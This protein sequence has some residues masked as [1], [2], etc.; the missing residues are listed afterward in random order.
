[1]NG[2]IRWF[3]G[4]SVAANFLMLTV[5]AAGLLSAW[6]IKREL[7]PP[8]TPNV[9]RVS[10]AYP[11]ATPVE[12]EEGIILALEEALS[13]LPGFDKMT[14][15]AAEGNGSVTLEISDGF[16]VRN[17]LNDTKGRVDSIRNF[18]VDAEKPIVDS[19]VVTRSILGLAVYGNL[20]ERGLRLVA[21]QVRDDLL[22]L[23]GLTQV[24][25]AAA[26]AYEIAIEVSEETLRRYGMTLDE[27]AGAV[28]KSSLDLPAGSIKRQGGEILLRS[29]GQA[30]RGE[31]FRQLILR[32]DKNGG[33][34]R[35]QDVAKVRDGFADVDLYSKF[36]GQRAILVMVSQVGNQDIM[37]I[38]RQVRD[39]V[40]EAPQRLQ[41]GIG[42]SI[43]QDS[44][45]LYQDRMNTLTS[46]A[47]NGLILVFIALALFLRL[48]LAIWV[49][50]GIPMSFLGA[51][52]IM[53]MM[54][55]SLN[56][57]SMFAFILVLGIVVDDAIVVSEAIHTDQENGKP[58]KDGA[59]SGVLRVARPVMM[60]VITTLIAFAP[61]LFMSGVEGSFWR[62][63][64]IV[65]IASL[66]FSLVE[67]LLILPAHLC[68][69]HYTGVRSRW[70]PLYWTAAT[71]DVVSVGL[72]GFIHR[73]YLPLLKRALAWRY[74]TISIFF[75]LILAVAGYYAGGHLRFTGFPSFAGD[76]IAVKIEMPI[77]SHVSATEQVLERVVTAL[78]SIRPLYDKDTHT[79]PKIKPVFGHVLLSVGATPGESGR[80]GRGGSD[81]GSGQLAEVMLQC[82][83]LRERGVDIREIQKKWEQLVGQPPGIK[84][85][86]FSNDLGNRGQD[87]ALRLIGPDAKEL[88]QASTW[89]QNELRAIDGVY[90]TQ[91]NFSDGKEEI[92]LHIT[93]AAQTLGLRQQDL[94]RQVRQA[95]YGEEVQRILRGRDEI[96]VMVRYPEEDRRRLDTLEQMR[97]RTSQGAEVPFNDV[98]TVERQLG[99][100]SIRR[101]NR[102]R[103]IKITGD[104]DRTR[105]DPAKINAAFT[106]R[107]LPELMTRYPGV[108]G[109]FT[110]SVERQNQSILELK[111][112]FG[113]A[114]FVMYA[115]MAI[116]FRSYLQPALIMTAIPFGVVGAILG[117]LLIG[118]DLSM[119]SVM[120]MIALSGVV[121]NDNLVLID[122]INTIRAEGKSLSV[123]V[124]EAAT[125]RFRAVMLTTL[126][127]F[128]GLAP[129]ILETSVQAQFLIP[130]AVS[131]AFGVV[132]ATTITLLFVPI[133]YLVLEDV[134]RAGH[135]VFFGS[136]VASDKHDK[137]DN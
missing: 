81:S 18:P 55:A 44:S 13:D 89:L 77:G 93:P 37:A 66:S 33:I 129:L 9:V 80:M 53:P 45:V 117:H 22:R 105:A 118:I 114:L 86:T 74:L 52:W 47:I 51:L 115:V 121:V 124:V 111:I 7:I 79:D 1:M 78:E 108:K 130:M 67:S 84:A 102:E 94:A 40:A 36:N 2:L 5:V 95:F 58:G 119:L 6:N 34:V 62:L 123:A 59:I 76:S 60:A 106:D 20:D 75:S 21:E 103:L 73:L 49:T 63:I 96:K 15:T 70:S 132:F 87:I 3:A 98:A 127:T 16:D 99:S 48:R 54:D 97:V 128:V 35:L 42:L 85:I 88:R 14:A 91:D 24:A 26:P 43:W 10:V 110:G 134:M 39:Y 56:M 109:T 29:K 57:I 8:A 133:I 50:L 17:I 112:G 25:L 135:W 23:D 32:T 107:L 92:V 126:T 41:S 38:S 61:M 31:E 12:V 19:P 69:P 90:R 83:N 46:N 122:A 116:T 11:G 4:N 100:P 125:S 28:R 64:P 113:F 68:H 30:Y 27:V 101:L 104:V 82:H 137:A 120:G 65:V 131:L 136:T 71:Q 72:Q